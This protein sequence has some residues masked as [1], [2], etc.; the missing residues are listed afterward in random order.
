MATRREFVGAAAG[1]A[2]SGVLAR[3]LSPVRVTINAA[4][5]FDPWIEVIADHLRH[6]VGVTTR[7]AGGRPIL[8]VVK[9]NGYGLGLAQVGPV[10]DRLPAISGLAVVRPAEALVLRSTGTKKPILVMA[11]TS[12]EE[13][14]ELARRDVR[15]AFLGD[16]SAELCRRVARRI[17]RAVKGHLYLDTGMSRMGYPIARADA[18]LDRIAKE[19]V[20]IE[21]AFTELTE[22]VEFDRE[23]VGKL[24]A[25]AARA[26]A[27]GLTV[28]PLHAASSAG[29]DHQ[30]ETLLDLVRPGFMLYGGLVSDGA[31]SRGELKAAFRLKARVVRVERLEAGEGVSYHRRWKAT[32]PTWIAALPLGHVDGFPSGATKGCEALVN[33]KLYPVVGSV[34]ASHTILALGSEPEVKV[35]DVA[36]LIGPDHPSI[37]PDVVATRAE[38]SDYGIYFHLSP[39]L[40]RV[41]V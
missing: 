39:T 14:I 15:I 37:H 22:D 32:E 23:Q 25:W 16:D 33:G 28:G 38:Y 24:S 40:K 1:L 8:A 12:E 9:N 2:G 6:N 13:A 11:R 31:R 27:R 34:S 4:E 17:G 35:G 41:V 36:T 26:R 18:W 29:V 7:M 21:G 5:R 19:Q 20:R 10:L 30:P 3:R